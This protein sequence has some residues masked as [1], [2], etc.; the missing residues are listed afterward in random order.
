MFS[1]EEGPTDATTS[2]TDAAQGWTLLLVSKGAAWLRTPCRQRIVRVPA[3]FVYTLYPYWQSS[4]L[5][6]VDI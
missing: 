5:V 6:P 3:P 2:G 4:Y 1:A